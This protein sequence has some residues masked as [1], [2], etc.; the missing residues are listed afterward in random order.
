MTL[1]LFGSYTIT[2]AQH[3]KKGNLVKSYM[4][5]RLTMYVNDLTC[6]VM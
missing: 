6:R 1:P 5:Q 4:L 2:Q 3:E